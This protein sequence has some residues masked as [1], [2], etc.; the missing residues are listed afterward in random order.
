VKPAALSDK[1]IVPLLSLLAIVPLFDLLLP[2]DL[3]LTPSMSPVLVYVLVALG[4]TVATGFTGL[5]HLGVSAFI[6]IGAYSFAILAC[7]IYP[8]QF[9]WWLALATSSV[10]GAIVG[11]LLA[12]PTI[13]LRGD[14]L[15]IVT[16]GFGEI[17]QDVLRNID[18]VTKGSQGINPLSGPDFF[19]FQLSGETPT[20]WYYVILFFVALASITL[21]RLIQS[22]TGREWKALRDDELAAS[23]MGINPVHTKLASFAISA[24]L[25]ALAGALMASLLGS[26]GEPSNYDFQVSIMALSMVIVG[27]LG[28]IP[29][30]MIGAILMVGINSVV[31]AK[32]A[33]FV[34]S[35]ADASSN[36][37]LVPAN[38]KY[39][40]FGLALV[41]MMRFKSSGLLPPRASS[42]GGTA[43]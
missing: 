15:A 29:G 19:G 16:L 31:L 38:W 34:S 21:D 8:F 32:I 18:V 27:G 24:A 7:P 13:R 2:Q 41:I 25:C 14:Y 3:R 1:R 26:S 37:F 30:A 17:M 33:D 12:I 10:I 35:T 40:I 5:L 11:T 20:A 36:V 4:L 39:L 42:A 23:S 28:S 43:R 6:A 9:P 22:P